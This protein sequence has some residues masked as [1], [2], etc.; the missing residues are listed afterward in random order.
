ML[1]MEPTQINKEVAE[2]KYSH[3]GV[4]MI[5]PNETPV[6]LP[7]SHFPAVKHAPNERSLLPSSRIK[8]TPNSQKTPPFKRPGDPHVLPHPSGS[9]YNNR[10]AY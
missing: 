10:A 7:H 4:A 8:Q 5:G 2:S 6:I 3:Y 9:A 1:K